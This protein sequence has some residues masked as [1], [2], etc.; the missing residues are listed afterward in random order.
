M[1]FGNKVDDIDDPISIAKYKD[2]FK[3]KILSIIECGH[4]WA[5]IIDDCNP[6]IDKINNELHDENYNLIKIDHSDLSIGKLVAAVIIENESIII[7]RA[8]VIKLIGLICR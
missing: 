3:I 1:T 5:K 2:Q 7:H 6:I 4:F 8:K